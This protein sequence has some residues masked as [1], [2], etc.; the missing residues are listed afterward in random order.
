MKSSEI[1]IGERQ[2]LKA[3]WSLLYNLENTPLPQSERGNRLR[4]EGHLLSGKTRVMVAGGGVEH[5]RNEWVGQTTITTAHSPAEDH[6]TSPANPSTRTSPSSPFNISCGAMGVH[7]R[8][9]HT[10]T[11]IFSLTVLQHAHIMH[12]HSPEQTDMYY[13]D[14]L[15]QAH[16]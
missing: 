15:I 10:H 13:T 3:V 14:V 2:Q 8:Y 12:A 4:H 5:G 16:T 7:N 6:D 1:R 9:T 11:L